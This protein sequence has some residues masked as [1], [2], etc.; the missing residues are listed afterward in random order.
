MTS[1][2]LASM[3]HSLEHAYS[4]VER[5]LIWVFYIGIC[6]VVAEFNHDPLAARKFLALSIVAL[7]LSRKKKL[8][9]LLSEGWCVRSLLK[10]YV[11]TC[12]LN[13]Y[14]KF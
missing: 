10:L 8:M 9:R 7:I 3:F 1:L 4:Y 11:H 14:C 5:A 6:G 13:R 12:K 2:R